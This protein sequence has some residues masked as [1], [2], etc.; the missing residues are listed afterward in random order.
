M[1]SGHKSYKSIGIRE[2][3]GKNGLLTVGDKVDKRN[4]GSSREIRQ[5]LTEKDRVTDES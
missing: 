5:L 4:V 2:I 3:T 1:A